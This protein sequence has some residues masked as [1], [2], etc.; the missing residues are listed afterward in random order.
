MYLS[1]IN[2]YNLLKYYTMYVA[3]HYTNIIILMID[4]GHLKRQE[5]LMRVKWQK[6]LNYCDKILQTQLSIKLR[7]NVQIIV[8]ANGKSCAKC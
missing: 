3:W 8:V 4:N 1:C 5:L 2:D 6:W 7:N